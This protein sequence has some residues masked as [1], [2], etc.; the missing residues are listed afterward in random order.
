MPLRFFAIFITVL[1]S[2]SLLV[3]AVVIWRLSRIFEF[4]YTWKSFFGVVLL[5]ANFL[6]VIFLARVVW[7]LAMRLWF[8][9]MVSY[10][11][12]LWLLFTVLVGYAVV[13][14]AAQRVWPIPPR[15]S[16]AIVIIATVTLVGY[17]LF[18][19]RQLTVK[20]IAVCSP[21]IRAPL[22]IVQLTDLHIG[23]INGK[24][25]VQ[26]IVSQTNALLPDLV[27]LTGDVVDL[28]ATP[29]MLASFARLNA[30]AFFVWGNHDQLLRRERV[31]QIFRALP[32]TVLQNET[33]RFR[34]DLQIIGLDYL[35]RQPQNDPKPILA[36]LLLPHD[37][38][39]LL[40]SHAPL[41]FSR[42]DGQ[43]IDLQLAGHTHAGQIFPFNLIVKRLY[44]RFQGLYTSA[45]RA[46]YVSSGTGTWGPPMRLGTQ[47]E[48]TVIRLAPAPS[49]TDRPLFACR[50]TSAHAQEIR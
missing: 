46:I 40:L 36:R 15:V 23:A 26:R 3:H 5:T 41:D 9:A 13:Q 1:F 14:L 37:L 48:I 4:H 17:S 22:T 29:D 27:V 10:I 42:L 30:P 21:K 39:T 35:E 38:F 34:N 20:T 32:I 11:G 43:P 19:A 31:T 45:E 18:N 24:T 33:V 28:G 6:A 47:N 49:G 7:N 12:V 8:V 2:V 25:F 50:E 44:P 16:Q